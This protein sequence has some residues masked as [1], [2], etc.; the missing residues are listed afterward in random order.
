MKL[1][2]CVSLA[3][4]VCERFLISRAAVTRDAVVLGQL[5]GSMDGWSEST[6]MKSFLM[7]PM[8]V[9]SCEALTLSLSLSRSLSF[10]RSE[11][12]GAS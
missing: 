8:T 11:S 4:T 9:E 5:S 6:V 3:V 10:T 1:C 2:V 7:L 12:H